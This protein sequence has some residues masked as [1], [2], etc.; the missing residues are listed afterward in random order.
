V[1]EFAGAVLH[2]AIPDYEIWR[3]Q[4]RIAAA[5]GKSRHLLKPVSK[6]LLGK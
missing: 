6:K 1:P 3:C 2:C 4:L 5:G